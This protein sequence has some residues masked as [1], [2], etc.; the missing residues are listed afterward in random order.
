MPIEV[1][2]PRSRTRLRSAAR[3]GFPRPTDLLAVAQRALVRP[4][5]PALR[6]RCRARPAARPATRRA[7][8][9]PRVPANPEAAYPKARRT[10]WSLF[11]IRIRLAYSS[12]LPAMGDFA[13]EL[14]VASI[15][16]IDLVSADLIPELR[17]APLH[18]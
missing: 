11:P 3:G 10:A 15:V 5:S 6:N 13:P 17:G 2:A 7:H 1:P 4:V 12:A 16:E 14:R 18:R 9:A 8:R